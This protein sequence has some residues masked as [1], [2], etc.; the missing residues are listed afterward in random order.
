M[1]HG[2]VSLYDTGCTITQMSALPALQ[3]RRQSLAKAT[4]A[5]LLL[6]GSTPKGDVKASDPSTGQVFPVSTAGRRPT[7]ALALRNNIAAFGQHEGQVY[8]VDVNNRRKVDGGYIGMQQRH[9]N[10]VYALHILP[11]PIKVDTNG[12]V[13]GQ[14]GLISGAVDGSILLHDI[15]TG[16]CHGFRN[17]PAGPF[18]PRTTITFLDYYVESNLIIA[19]TSLGEIWTVHSQSEE[20]MTRVEGTKHNENDWIQAQEIFTTPNTRDVW[21][22]VDIFYLSDMKNDSIIVIRE[23]S[24]V[25]YGIETPSTTRFLSG[26]V[27]FTCAAIDPDIP[28]SQAPRLFV[29]GDADGTVSVF[30]ARASPEDP[31]SSIP[32]VYTVIPTP[33]MSIKALAIN[34][35]TLITGSED[36][37]AK[38]YHTLDGTFIRS[39][40]APSSRRRH[41]RPPPSRLDEVNPIAAISLT[42][43]PKN[44]VRGAIGFRNGSIRYW[45]FAPDG[46]GGVIKVKKR[47]KPRPTAKEIKTFVDDEI[48]RD[49]LESMEEEGRRRQWER[50][51]GGIEEEDVALQVALMMSR[52]EEDRRREWQAEIAEESVEEESEEEE[53]DEWIPGR[54]ISMGSTSGASSPAVRN[55]TDRRFEDVLRS[56]QAEQERQFDEDLNFAIRLSLAEQQS[57]E[58]SQPPEEE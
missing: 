29:V 1:G 34:P 28:D 20:D 37:T 46:V 32:A 40:C 25:R 53:D 13:D 35:I 42:Q 6:S 49:V 23:K 44:E 15:R 30:N 9:N 41:L 10:V 54:K 17:L 47:R 12:V 21:L 38:T 31:D 11:I 52:E 3:K 50:M 43:T 56:R 55:D 48:E 22:S 36:G 26:N 51:N 7:N 27:I 45:N 8:I 39:L 16:I 18:L 58:E 5:P 19:G 2:P 24:I 14:I 57:R 4:G 33:S